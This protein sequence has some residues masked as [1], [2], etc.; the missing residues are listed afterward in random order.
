[1]VNITLDERDRAVL[2]RLREGEADVESVAESVSASAAHLRERLPELADNGLVERTG[3]DRYAVTSNGERVVEASPAGTKDNRI[4]T[5]PDVEG[6][7]ASFDL[8]PDREEAVRNAFAFL[9]YWG[10]ASESEIIDDVYSEDPAGFESREEWAE[11]V[12]EHLA[13]LPSVEPPSGDEEQWR[14]TGTAIVE[15]P[16]DDGRNV[17]GSE[18]ASDSSAKFALERLEMDEDERSAVRAAFGLLVTEN[19]ADAD[20]IRDRVYPDHSAGYDSPDDWWDDCV[21]DAFE[22]LPGVERRDGDEERWQYR[23]TESGAASS[24]PGAELPDDI[25]APSHDDG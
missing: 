9:H 17:L 14:F 2:E 1:M 21:R 24:N 10:A 7:I 4:D 16:T 19:E 22:S 15:E 6:E 5:P 8:P 18:D 12:R 3:D 25:S 23:Q 13:R 11:F 20:G